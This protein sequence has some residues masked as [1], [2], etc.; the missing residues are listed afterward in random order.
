MSIAG[1]DPVIPLDEVINTMKSVG[2]S[3]PCSL[4][5]TGLG[6]LSVTPTSKR[7]YEELKKNK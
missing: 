3:M 2:E 5:C 6:G 7:I 4:R 1:Y